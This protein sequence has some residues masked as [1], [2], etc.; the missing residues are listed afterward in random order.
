MIVC[1]GRVHTSPVQSTNPGFLEYDGR[2]LA[3]ICV[4]CK[5]V[6]VLSGEGL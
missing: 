4:K 5:N 1:D 6:T 2:P 3:G